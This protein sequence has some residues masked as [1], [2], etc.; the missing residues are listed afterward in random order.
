VSSKAEGLTLEGCAKPR[1]HIVTIS[2]VMSI[3]QTVRTDNHGSC[4]NDFCEKLFG[5]LY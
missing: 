3:R 4:L 5:K 1:K 2:F